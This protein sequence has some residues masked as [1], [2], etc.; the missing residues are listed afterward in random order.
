MENKLKGF[1][2]YLDEEIVRKAKII[3]AEKEEKLKKSGINQKSGLL[4]YLLTNWVKEEEDGRT[5]D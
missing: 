5:T 2:I 3:M 4:N 1:H